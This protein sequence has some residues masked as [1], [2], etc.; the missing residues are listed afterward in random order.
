MRAQNKWRNFIVMIILLTQ[1]FN[2]YSKD[3]CPGGHSPSAVEAGA[4][5][6]VLMVL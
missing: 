6:I 3:V 1:I 4:V 2:V 5:G